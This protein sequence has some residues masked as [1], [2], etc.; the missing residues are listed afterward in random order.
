M[1]LSC[2]T[3]QHALALVAGSDVFSLVG[4]GVMR[5]VLWLKVAILLQ[6]LVG[7]FTSGEGVSTL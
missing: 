2:H 3:G 5:A 4:T 6:D 7:L 1:Q